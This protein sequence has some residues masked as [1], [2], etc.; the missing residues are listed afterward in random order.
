MVAT[1]QAWTEE[2]VKAM[3]TADAQSTNKQGETKTYTGE[4]ISDLQVKG[5]VEIQVR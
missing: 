4:L 5:V 2:E 1:E 3:P